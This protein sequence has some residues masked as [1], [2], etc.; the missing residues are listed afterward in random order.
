M[1]ASTR[2]MTSHERGVTSSA[3]LERRS[4][5]PDGRAT[6]S[7]HCALSVPDALLDDTESRPHG[8]G[9]LEQREDAL[10]HARRGH[11]LPSAHSHLHDV[12]VSS[13][14]RAGHAGGD[15]P[16]HRLLLIGAGH[17]PARMICNPGCGPLKFAHSVCGFVLLPGRRRRHRWHTRV[18][19][20]SRA[21][22]H[23]NGQTYSAKVM[24]GW[25]DH[26]WRSTFPALKPTLVLSAAV[27]TALDIGLDIQAAEENTGKPS[28]PGSTTI[29]GALSVLFSGFVQ[30]AG[31][32]WALFFE[33]PQDQW[34]QADKWAVAN[35][36]ML[37]LPMITDTGFLIFSKKKAIQR[38]PRPRLRDLV[39]AA[40]SQYGSD[41]HLG[42]SL[43]G[44][45]RHVPD[46][47]HEL[48]GDA[49]SAVLRRESL[50]ARCGSETKILRPSCASLFL[51]ASKNRLIRAL[52]AVAIV[53][54][55][56]KIRRLPREPCE[57]SVRL[58]STRESRG[59]SCRL[60][61]QALDLTQDRVL[62]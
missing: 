46:H 15:P 7:G 62:L 4:L 34:N 10:H 45:A 52:A 28:V 14:A 11:P 53:R 37:F 24:L 48:V 18:N 57:P 30:A 41:A 9:C 43:A 33:K 26:V 1:V 58:H 25:S 35:W 56:S 5:R 42:E 49:Y 59:K 17:L 39:H 23:A 6:G 16:A 12:G 2:C 38:F 40:K 61:F 44:T 22:A 13:A 51:Q 32:P 36:A 60:Q 27:Y 55:H 50:R 19:T 31:A 54:V 20:T 21:H 3:P 47:R 8:V 29:P